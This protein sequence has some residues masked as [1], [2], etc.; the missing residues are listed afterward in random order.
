MSKLHEGLAKA[1]VPKATRHLF[2]CI[3]PDCCRM[4]EGEM[5]WDYM[6]KRVKDAG[7][8]VMR[9][10]A[11]CFRVCTRGPLMVVYPEGTWYAEVT[12][13]RFE[14]ILQEHLVGGHPVKEWVVAQN[15]LG[16]SVVTRAAH[17][18][19]D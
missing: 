4:R 7:L 2:V 13:A 8:R 1:G 3:G 5:L 19:E 11:G 18:A 17:D 16:C 6:K 12:P 15:D 14:R 10:K 9:T